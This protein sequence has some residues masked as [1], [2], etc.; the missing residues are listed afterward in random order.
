[1]EGA[2]QSQE[3]PPCL[4]PRSPP[5]QGPGPSRL[6]VCDGHHD[7]AGRTGAP[8]SAQRLPGGQHRR[9]SGLATGSPKGSTGEKVGRWGAGKRR[10][11]ELSFSWPPHTGE[12]Q[13]TLVGLQL[14]RG[15][16]RPR[17]L[18]GHTARTGQA[19]CAQ[20]AAGWLCWA[21]SRRSLRR[22]GSGGGRREQPRGS[23]APS[24][25]GATLWIPRR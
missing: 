10:P 6:P 23:G 15:F 2:Q 24:L 3:P 20:A 7:A 16:G 12:V 17:S 1:M 8:R 5:W 4:P 13:D 19:Q 11:P 9:V 22:P 21:S 14:P 18:I 25:V